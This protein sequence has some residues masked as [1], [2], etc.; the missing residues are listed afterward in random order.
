MLP[1]VFSQD[2]KSVDTLMPYPPY[3]TYPSGI[4][5]KDKGFYRYA[6]NSSDYPNL[7]I[8]DPIYGHDGTVILPGYYALILS[9]D[10][11]FLLLAQSEKL[12][13]VFPVFKLEE[14]KIQVDQLTD[15]KYQ[16][17]LAKERKAQAKI[18][19]K[20]ARSGLGPEIKEVYMKA[21]IEYDKFGSYYLVKYERERIRAWG[22]IKE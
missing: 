3:P 21:T 16:R 22:A 1:G 20:R 15:K 12:I 10:R 2:V 8:V 11:N 19:K 14:D 17:K 9:D 13:A 7:M 4:V 18:D 5:D 6:K